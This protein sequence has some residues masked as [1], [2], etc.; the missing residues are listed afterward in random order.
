MH[1]IG[2]RPKKLKAIPFGIEGDVFQRG[3]FRF[4]H[5]RVVIGI[6]HCPMRLA[7]EDGEMAKLGRNGRP[8]LHAG[9][10][11]ADH[12]NALAIERN[13]VIPARGVK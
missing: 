9:C 5:H 7:L 2:G 3:F 11:G 1:T 13:T 6:M 10:P 4:R 12:R 8:G